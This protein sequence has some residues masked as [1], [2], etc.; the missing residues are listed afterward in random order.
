MVMAIVFHYLVNSAFRAFTGVLLVVSLLFS[1][2]SIAATVSGGS[3]GITV[4]QLPESY[5]SVQLN[6][7]D[8]TQLNSENGIFETA[9]GFDD[10]YY[11]YKILSEVAVKPSSRMNAQTLNNGRDANVK[12]ASTYMKVIESK[13]FLI[14]DGQVVNPDLAEEY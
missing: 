8:G 6:S 3:D 9:E 10:G 5:S 12:P 1:S 2:S 7:D 11:T 13:R 14:Q 4:L